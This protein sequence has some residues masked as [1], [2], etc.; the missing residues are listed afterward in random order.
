[1]SSSYR[2]R[3]AISSRQASR[4]SRRR[5][6]LLRAAERVEHVELERRA[7]EPAL[8]ELA[9][10]RDEPLGRCGDVLAGDR[11][12]PRVRARAPVAEDAPRDHEP[13]LAFGPQLRERGELLVVEEA[14]RDVE[15]RLDVRLRPLGADRRGI[16]PCSEEEPDRLREDRLPRARLPRDRVEPGRERELRLADE[17]EVLDPEPT[18]QSSGGSDGRTSPPAASRAASAPP[19]SARPH[20]P[21]SRAWTR[22]GRRRGRPLPRRPSGSTR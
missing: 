11:A 16:R 10:H 1:M 12:S 20:G 4:A 18:K 3:A 21:P 8:L 2:R 5:S 9:R 15:L 14:V 6:S 22:G 19:R 17:D 13:G 7:R